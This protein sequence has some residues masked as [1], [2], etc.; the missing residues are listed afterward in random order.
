LNFGY[1]RKTLKEMERSLE[2]LEFGNQEAVYVS[3]I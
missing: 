3:K 2:E 1:P